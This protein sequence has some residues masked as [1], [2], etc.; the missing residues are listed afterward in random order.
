MEQIRSR[1]EIKA[2]QM[3]MEEVL[4]YI[5]DPCMRSHF[6]SFLSALRWVLNEKT[7]IYPGWSEKK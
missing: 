3:E 4:S 1:E 2:V 5:R 6:D 7:N